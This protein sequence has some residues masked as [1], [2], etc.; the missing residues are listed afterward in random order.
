M[1]GIV[2]IF[3]GVPIAVF[4]FLVMRNPMRLSILA[5][6]EEGYY[7]R[8]VLNTSSRNS[9]R[10]FGMLICLFG[11]GISASASGATFKTR[12]LH[13]ISDGLWALMG[14][15]FVALWCFGVGFAIW[16]TLT[17]KSVGWSEWFQMRKK[18]IDLGPIEVFPSITE[19]MRKEA[20]IF[21]VGLCVLVSFAAVVALVR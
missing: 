9:L 21:T 1:G 17:G 18:G 11:S 15:C 16:R 8:M 13:N 6:G 5:S 10:A 3:I 12:A 14:I 19:Q 2:G 20:I 4:G 7:Q